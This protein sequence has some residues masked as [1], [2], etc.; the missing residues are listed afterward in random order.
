MKGIKE[1][2]MLLDDEQITPS[3]DFAAE[4]VK[5]YS[6][7]DPNPPGKHSYPRRLPIVF[8]K[9]KRLEF[10]EW[11]LTEAISQAWKLA[12]A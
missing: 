8:D 4:A 2:G 1:R 6:A 9:D 7:I 3:L 12:T 5:A 10:W 11:W